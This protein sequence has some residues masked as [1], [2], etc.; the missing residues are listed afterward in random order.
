MVSE[1][2]LPAGTG[3]AF[4]AGMVASA[5]TGAAAIWLVL[6]VVKTSTF[7]PFV[8]YRVVAGAAVLLLLATGA[9]LIGAA[10]ARVTT[11]VVTANAT[12]AAS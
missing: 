5:V 3:G 10:S 8:I 1:G 11:P 12:L 7:T 2:G 4:V 9:S 6:R